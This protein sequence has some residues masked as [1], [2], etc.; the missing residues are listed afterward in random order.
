MFFNNEELCCVRRIGGG[1]FGNVY[2]TSDSKCLK[3]ISAI[4]VIT[5]ESELYEIYAS[6]QDAK[7]LIDKPM[8]NIITY[9]GSFENDASSRIGILTE[10][11]EVK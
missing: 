6:M 9:L 10:Y 4:K 1:S 8:N 11:I 2:L 7:V 3:L 5:N